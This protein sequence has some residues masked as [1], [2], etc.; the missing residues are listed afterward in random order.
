MLPG[1][2]YE[3]MSFQLE[4]G[5]LLALYSDGVTEAYDENEAEWGNERFAACLSASACEPAPVIV[6]RVFAEIDRF[7]G[8]APQ[9]DDITL[10]ILKR[11]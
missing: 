5:D 7:A 6:D 10:L 1:L 2:P 8:S 4:P 3:E 9:H 11:D